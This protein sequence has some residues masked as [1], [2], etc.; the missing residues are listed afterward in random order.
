MCVCLD[1][2][3]HRALSLLFSEN[4]CLLCDARNACDNR[5]SGLYEKYAVVFVKSVEK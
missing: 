5:L 3:R 4:L 1:L 2:Y